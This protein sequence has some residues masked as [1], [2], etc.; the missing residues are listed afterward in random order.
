MSVD[1]T[2]VVAALGGQGAFL[3]AAV[4][5]LKSG[6][7]QGLNRDLE[8]YKTELKSKSDLEIER[9]KNELRSKTDLEIERVKNELKLAELEHDVR[10]SRL[11]DRRTEVIATLYRLMVE[12]EWLAQAY[13]YGEKS[14]EQAKDA[15]AKTLELRRE[16]E[17]TRL[18]LPNSVCVVMSKWI[19]RV[20]SIVNAVKIYFTDLPHPNPIMIPQQDEQMRRVVEAFETEVPGIKSLLESEF[21]RLLGAADKDERNEGSPRAN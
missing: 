14:P 3:L 13:A 16:F 20:F 15:L 8:R 17:R 5:L 7:N 9:V 19:Q 11:H 18:Y 4:W 1:W 21:R 2:T 12:A 6:I 10:F